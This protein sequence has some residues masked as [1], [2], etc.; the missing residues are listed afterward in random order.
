MLNEWREGNEEEI[1]SLYVRDGGGLRGKRHT[2]RELIMLSWKASPE[3][4]FSVRLCL[5][6]ITYIDGILTLY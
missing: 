6:I 2:R 5:V 4:Q 1:Q 3:I